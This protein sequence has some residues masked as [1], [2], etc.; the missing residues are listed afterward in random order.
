M[1]PLTLASIA[2]LVFAWLTQAANPSVAH[3]QRTMARM[4][5]STPEN[6]A[7][8]RWMFYGQS[9]TAQAWTKVVEKDL[10]RR[11]P[12]VKFVF[13]KPA[14]GGFTS[15]A[16]IRTAEHDLYPWYPDLLVFHVY[17]PVDKYEEI[18]RR[19]R[20]R[21][22]AEIVLWTSH[23]SARETL[24]KNPDADAR[25][26]AI[27]EIAKRHDCMLIDVRKKWIAHLQE[28]TL[29]PSDLLRDGVHLNDDGVALLGSLVAP[30]LLHEPSLRST[31]L[32]GSVT[33]VPF[34][35]PTLSF[36]G[37][38]VV[39][40]SGGPGEG[41][42]EILLDGEPL[43]PR[44]ELWATT[45]PSTAPKMWMPAIKQIAFAKPP[46]SEEWTLTCLPDSTAD[47]KRVHFRI[48]GSVTG[49]DG[50]GFSDQRFVSNSGRVVI[51]PADW[52]LAWCLQ[53]KK[54]ELPKG[55]QIRWQ[56]Y[57]LFAAKYEPQPRGTETLLLQNCANGAHQLTLSGPNSG[58]T[59]FRVYAPHQ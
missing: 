11:F 55:F 44:S 43:S 58:I 46:V 4:A 9:I 13:H 23:L 1:K 50:E 45:R 56:T 29:A 2:F 57:P 16:L 49:V 31:P 30:E 26:V 36:T 18:I 39:A 53:Y 21:T 17:G 25:I 19:V 24:D 28:K 37:N 54:L 5:A 41:T 14:I 12:S 3:I 59:A 42:V 34:D 47:G 15:P 35:S 52:H 27:R 10:T 51:D 22:T 40:I 8:V 48:E 33:E 6:P 38:R 7:T 20:A 32:A